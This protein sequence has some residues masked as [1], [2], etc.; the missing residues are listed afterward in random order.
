MS[1]FSDLLAGGAAGL[2]AGLGSFAK[3]LREA[4]TGK[5]ILDPNQQAEILMKMAAIEAAAAQAVVDY[6]QSQME[7]QTAIAKLEAASQD[8]YVTRWRP[9]IGWICGI[10]LLYTFLMKPILPFIFQCGAL[11]TGRDVSSVPALPEVPMGDLIILLAGMLGLGG[12][13]SVEK[14]KGVRK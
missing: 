2:F 12:M 6:D 5:T 13:R 4:I 1:F 3:D 11:I 8:K 10:G 7:G 9:T 14:I